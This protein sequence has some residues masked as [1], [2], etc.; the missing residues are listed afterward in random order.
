MIATGHNL[1][2]DACGMAVFLLLVAMHRWTRRKGIFIA[3]LWNLTGVVLHELA[4][5]LS[6]L[7]LGAGPTGFSII[8]RRSDTGWKLGSVTF[9]KVNAFNAVPV[10]LAPLGLAFAAYI[11]WQLWHL[12][13]EPAL[14]STIWLYLVMFILL[15]NAA[16]SRQDLRIA[17]NWKSLLLYGSAIT[18]GCWLLYGS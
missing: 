5:L 9:R 13:F 2:W 16:P 6:G 12:W 3:A 1:L 14:S 7:I 17:C 10:A 11:V 4:H 8:P 18:A 15:Y